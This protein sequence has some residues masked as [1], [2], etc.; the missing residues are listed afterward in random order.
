MLRVERENP[1]KIRVIGLIESL[2]SKRK[3]RNKKRRL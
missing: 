2:E 3:R 1:D